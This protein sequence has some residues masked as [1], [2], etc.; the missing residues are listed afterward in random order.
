MHHLLIA[1][2]TTLLPGLSL[3]VATKNSFIRHIEGLFKEDFSPLNA[4]TGDSQLEVTTVYS[5]ATSSGSEYFSQEVFTDSECKS[6]AI[7]INSLLNTC[8]EC[9]GGNGY[10][11]VNISSH[12]STFQTVL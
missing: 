9:E 6:L 10:A 7:G 3:S 2:A 12:F 8:Y 5:S 11:K 1:V 4:K